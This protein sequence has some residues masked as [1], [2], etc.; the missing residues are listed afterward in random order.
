MSRNGKIAPPPPA[1]N[2]IESDPDG[3]PAR[4]FEPPDWA[5]DLLIEALSG[6][7]ESG[8]RSTVVT[9]SFAGTLVTGR[10]VSLV[11]WTHG[12]KQWT[13]ES[14]PSFAEALETLF[15]LP[16]QDAIETTKRRVAEELPLPARQFIHLQDVTI[17]YGASATSMKFWR[18]RLSEVSGWA[19]GS[20]D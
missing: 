9:L 8:T 12:V 17:G 19:I 1:E 3:L 16:M 15:L 2:V 13:A 4:A 14:N 11:V 6:N 5:L 18:G 10:L 20:H 7:D